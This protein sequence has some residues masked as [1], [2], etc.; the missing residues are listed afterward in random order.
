MSLKYFFASSTA[1]SNLSLFVCVDF[2]ICHY[3]FVRFCVRC[4]GVFLYVSGFTCFCFCESSCACLYVY[5]CVIVFVCHC[6]FQL[7][8]YIFIFYCFCFVFVCC[9]VWVLKGSYSYF[10]YVFL[11][12]ISVLC[13]VV[14]LLLCVELFLCSV[15]VQFFVFIFLMM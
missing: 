14:Q 9:F 4:G 2:H 8:F 11:N 3:V 12:F 5:G 1:C 15:Y 10:L 13:V 6:G 7:F